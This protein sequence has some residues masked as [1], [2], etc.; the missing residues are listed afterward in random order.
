[1]PS[2]PHIPPLFLSNFTVEDAAPFQRHLNRLEVEIGREDYHHLKRVEKL[3]QPL[4]AAAV[5]GMT[6][7]TE[8][9]LA[10]TQNN[11][12]RS[13]LQELGVR[14]LFDQ[15]LYRVYYHLHHQS[16]RFVPV[17]REWVLDKFFHELPCEDTGWSGCDKVLPGFEAR[18]LPDEAGGSL[19]LRARSAVSGLPL[20]TAT[21]GPYDPHT[22]EVTLY[23][24]RTGKGGA[25]MVNLGFAGREPLTDS[26]LQL[27]R[28]WNLPLNPSNIDVIYPYV[29]E[30]GHPYCYKMER[31]LRQ[32]VDLLEIPTP[33]MLIDIHGCVGTCPEDR[34]VVVGLG[35]LPPFHHPEQFGRLERQG[36]VLHFFPG[37]RMQQGLRLARELSDEVFLQLCD[38]PHAC[39]HFAVLGGLQALG[40]RIDPRRDVASLLKGEERS[41][42]PAD[43]VRWLPGAG[44]NSLQRIE[45]HK[46]PGDP[47]CLH[48]E[49]P[50]AVR[51]KMVLR[52]QELAITDSLDSS[53]L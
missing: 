12:N 16:I 23:F 34:K 50:T 37:A 28:E 10:T 6:D 5:A 52:L 49:I 47:L 29:D 7:I 32:F 20:L 30:A 43:N 44:A 11:Y 1:M 36:E 27:L 15:R 41:Y 40:R 31:G 51:R 13:L 8:R 17:W 33:E 14:V 45:A 48:V 38:G 19:L 26:N 53:G 24:L 18:F 35:G 2:R 46:L 3:D 4:S 22:L 21:H 25:A 39:Y 42:L 9:L